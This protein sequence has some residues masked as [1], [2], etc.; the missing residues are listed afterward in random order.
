MNIW[1]VTPLRRDRLMPQITRVW[2]GATVL[3]PRTSGLVQVDLAVNWRHAL[4]RPD[5]R[6]EGRFGQNPTAVK[7][8]S[9]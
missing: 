9:S 1:R 2:Q 8:P 3:S 6:V 5:S 7:R 4:G